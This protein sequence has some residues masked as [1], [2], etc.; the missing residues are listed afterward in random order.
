LRSLLAGAVDVSTVMGELSAARPVFH[1]EADFQHAFVW[2]LHGMEPGLNVRLEVR[3]AEREYV[4]LLCFGPR[5]RT[6]V[7]FKYF[8]ATWA[9]A[10]PATGEE[11]Q[12]RNHEATD[13]ARQG[14]VFDI[15]RLEKF[16]A[17][18][19]TSNGVA[20]MVSNDRRLWSP[21]VNSRVTRDR[22]FRIHDG[23]TLSGLLR[24][25]TEGSYFAASER[26]LVDSY[27]VMWR[28]CSNVGGKNGVFRW[29][30][31]AVAQRAE[32]APPAA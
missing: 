20:I 21:A 31:A 18:H 7:E 28:D 6:V 13:L 27:Q 24:W 1:S 32:P 17:A 4:D 12:L 11:F 19:G 16:C 26:N 30:A 2:V 5:G 25:G 29:L 22:E 3:Q 10:D 14:F 9:G 23:R 8:T 15:A